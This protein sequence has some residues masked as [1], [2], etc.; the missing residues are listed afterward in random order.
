MARKNIA[1]LDV[2]SSTLS[3]MIGSLGFGGNVNV[4]GFAE[5]NYAG[6]LD[7]EFLEP[8]KLE[9]TIASVIALAQEN[10]N[11][12]ITHLYVGVPAEFGAVVVKQAEIDFFAEHKVT[13]A[14][15]TEL[16]EK[17]DV[18][19]DHQKYSVIN[20]A[21]IYFVA[22]D[23]ERTLKV[24]G[25]ITEKLSGLISFNLCDK[26]FLED[27][28]P[29]LSE[30]EF[31]HVEFL[32]EQLCES[33]YLISPD[34]RDNL[35]VLVDCG[36]LTTSVSIVMGDGILSSHHFALGAG[37]IVSDISTVFEV[38]LEQA[39]ELRRGISFEEDPEGQV[40]EVEIEDGE[41]KEIPVSKVFEIVDFRVNQI[42]KMIQKC[43]DASDIALPEFTPMFL[44]GGGISYIEGIADKLS[45]KFGCE[46]TIASPKD[47]TLNKPYLSSI[48][49]LLDL[50]LRKNKQSIGLFLGKLFKGGGK[51]NE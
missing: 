31:E 22:D 51:E 19:K 6:F 33:L 39:E 34:K 7:G 20:R 11:C 46:I 3:V 23:G 30:F 26:G 16:F 9:S 2:G 25:K 24:K 41:T 14:D 43:L 10:A 44:T 5:T 21:P 47:P 35:A 13:D 17:A 40:F 29:A 18:F 27:I 4:K 28:M 37:H 15:I 45:D 42:T 8:E 32:S 36:F 12:K 1:V 49:S 50:A 48:V 38:P